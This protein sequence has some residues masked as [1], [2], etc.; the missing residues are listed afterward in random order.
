MVF[1]NLV[2]KIKI[3][4]YSGFFIF[5]MAFVGWFNLSLMFSL[6]LSSIGVANLN[7]KW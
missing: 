7:M 1:I 4:V 3:V 5:K 6:S 2:F